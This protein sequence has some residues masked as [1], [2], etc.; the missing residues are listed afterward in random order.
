MPAP[1][2][3]QIRSV[4]ER[5]HNGLSS[6][7]RRLLSRAIDLERLAQTPATGATK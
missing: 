5:E 7:I 3:A 2:A 4:A 6:T 1:L